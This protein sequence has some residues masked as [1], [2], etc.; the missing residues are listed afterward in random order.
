[1]D[2]DDLVKGNLINTVFNYVFFDEIVRKDITMTIREIGLEPE[3]HPLAIKAY[4]A[5]DSVRFAM[6]YDTSVY[7]HVFAEEIAN[8][9][10]EIIISMI[11][12]CEN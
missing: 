4:S 3:F 7:S 10:H 1:M 5:K 9:Y 2:D 11:K 8:K 6:K 12:E